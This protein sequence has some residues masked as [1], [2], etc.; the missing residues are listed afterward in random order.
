MILCLGS[1]NY[2]T[3]FRLI[4]MSIKTDDIMIKA[5]ESGQ[6]DLRGSKDSIAAS[7][8]FLNLN[9]PMVLWKRRVIDVDRDRIVRSQIKN[10]KNRDYLC[11]FTAV[12]DCSISFP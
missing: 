11:S 1:V 10:N 3:C 12:D 9:K 6:Y 2:E 7:F 5:L 4:L 8:H